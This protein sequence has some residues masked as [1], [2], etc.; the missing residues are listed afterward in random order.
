MQ[1]EEMPVS[2]ACKYFDFFGDVYSQFLHRFP[3]FAIEPTVGW[4]PMIFELCKGEFN[5]LPSLKIRPLTKF[6]ATG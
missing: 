2:R 1:Q 6:L 3:A 4:P 5:S